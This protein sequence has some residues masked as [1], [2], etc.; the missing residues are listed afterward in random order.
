[1][2]LVNVIGAKGGVGT[3]TTAAMIAIS[4]ATTDST[5]VIVDRT[6]TGDVS[7]IV[8]DGSLTIRVHMPT[9]HEAETIDYCIID[10]PSRSEPTE[11]TNLLVVTNSFLAAS[12]AARVPT[13]VHGVIIAQHLPAH[14]S[15]ADIQTVLAIPAERTLVI[16]HVHEI[17]CLVDSGNLV[18][19]HPRSIARLHIGRFVREMVA[20][21]DANTVPV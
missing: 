18:S 19:R 2:K 21:C 13:P 15:V 6:G 5:V 4:L 8:A 3:S 9:E 17:A 14:L 1:M 20:Y 16:P 10:H 12:N 11:G 7:A